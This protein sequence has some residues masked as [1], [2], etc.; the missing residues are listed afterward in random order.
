MELIADDVEA[1]HVVVAP[2]NSTTTIEGRK[3]VAE[4]RLRRQIPTCHRNAGSTR[5]L[6]DL[7]TQSPA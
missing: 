3:S 7:V 2:I 5:R 4:S 1:F 6:I